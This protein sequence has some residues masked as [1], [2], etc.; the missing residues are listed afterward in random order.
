MG[1]KGVLFI[2]LN[3]KGGND[4]V[5]EL[6]DRVEVINGWRGWFFEGTVY[7][8]EWGKSDYFFIKFV[9]DNGKG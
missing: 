7:N 2:W 8:V 1:S 9:F 4:T 3:I 6:F 5:R